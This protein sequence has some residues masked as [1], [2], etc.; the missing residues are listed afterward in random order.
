MYDFG[1]RLKDLRRARGLTQKAL[2]KRINKSVSAIS[3]Y[4]SNAQLPSLDVANSIALTLGISL[5]C[6][7]GNEDIP[8]YSSAGLTKTQ[9]TIL[10]LLIAE[11]HNSSNHSPQLS[12][13]QLLIIKM[14]IESFTQ[15]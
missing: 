2:A 10:E 11:V 6:L 13:R 5:D 15:P 12:E 14:L 4:E 1:L 9:N 3:S 8:M 7:V